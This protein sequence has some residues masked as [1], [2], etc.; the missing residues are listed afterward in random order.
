MRYR[1][2]KWLLAAGIIAAATWLCFEGLL[3]GSEWLKLALGIGS[4]YLAANVTQKAVA[5][6]TP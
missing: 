2:R 1:S 6:E 4:A 5:K 3:A